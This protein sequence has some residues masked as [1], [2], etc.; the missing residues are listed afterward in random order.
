L[1]FQS[2]KSLE[3]FED[4]ANAVIERATRA[5]FEAFWEKTKPGASAGNV[6]DNFEMIV[7]G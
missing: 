1:P 5:E 7:V 3:F 2:T 4:V 6:W